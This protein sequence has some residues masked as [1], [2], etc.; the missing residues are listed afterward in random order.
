MKS[1]RMKTGGQQKAKHRSC[2]VNRIARTDPHCT[3]SCSN[4]LQFLISCWQILSNKL[5]RLSERLYLNLYLKFQPLESV[6]L[7]TLVLK[8]LDLLGIDQKKR[9]KL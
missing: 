7:P 1:I 8:E 5:R 2:V 3:V 6:H 9:L 4:L